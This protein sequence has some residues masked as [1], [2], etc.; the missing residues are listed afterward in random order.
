MPSSIHKS[1]K[2][3]APHRNLY[4][5][6]THVKNKHIEVQWNDIEVSEML[7][8][9]DASSIIQYDIDNAGE[10]YDLG[11]SHLFH[12]GIWADKGTVG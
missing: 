7:L 10:Q 1:F 2:T 8:Y 3:Y 5:I 9:K 6:F 11:K 12:L 4:Q